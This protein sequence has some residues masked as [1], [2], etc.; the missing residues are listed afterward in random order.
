MKIMKDKT[1]GFSSSYWTDD[2]LLNENS[3]ISEEV[4]AKYSS[5]LNAPFTEIRACV[6]DNC[7]YHKFDKAFS[8]AKELFAKGYIRDSSVDQDGILKSFLPQAGSYAVSWQCNQIVK[9]GLS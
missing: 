1:L 3:V 8:S 9:L 7:F 5:F 6:G 4:N 2:K